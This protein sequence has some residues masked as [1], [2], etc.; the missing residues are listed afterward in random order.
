MTYMSVMKKCLDKTNS[1]AAS[2]HIKLIKCENAIFSKAMYKE[3][4]K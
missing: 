1:V 4:V 2:Q 3:R